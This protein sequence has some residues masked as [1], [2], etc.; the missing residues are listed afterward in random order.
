MEEAAPA[1]KRKA[2]EPAES[3]PA[4]KK[5]K[6]GNEPPKTTLFVGNL[7]WNVDEDTLNGE[8]GAFGSVKNV[9]IITDRESG[10][11]KG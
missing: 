7:S 4:A 11:S 8:F 10:K 1:K 5:A 6:G 2:E 3:K 9:K